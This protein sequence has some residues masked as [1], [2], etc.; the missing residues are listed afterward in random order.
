MGDLPNEGLNAGTVA[1][2]GE[3]GSHLLALTIYE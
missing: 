2:H 1:A 3:A